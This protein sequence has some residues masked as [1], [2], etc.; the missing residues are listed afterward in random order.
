MAVSLHRPCRS[1]CGVPDG[2]GVRCVRRRARGRRLSGPDA[3]VSACRG[4]ARLATLWPVDDW[5]TAAL[6]ERF[7]GSG[8]SVA[9]TNPGHA[10]AVAQRGL[11]ATPATA[12][13]FYWAG[14]VSAGSAQ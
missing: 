5:A 14:F 1:V 4:K 7:Y 12:H 3:R 13:P 9:A 10:L 11:I 2:A 6:M 8:L